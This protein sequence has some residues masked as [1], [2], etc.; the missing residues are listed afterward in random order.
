MALFSI[1]HD[2]IFLP[3]SRGNKYL[4]ADAL[5]DIYNTFFNQEIKMPRRGDVVK[6]IYV[7]LKKNADQWVDEGEKYLTFDDIS[8]RGKRV[9]RRLGIRKRKNE[10]DVTDAALQRANHMF[11]RLT[12]CGWLEQTGR[13]GHETVDMPIGAMRLIKS[14]VD[15]RKGFSPQ[16]G[17]LLAQARTTLEGVAG[18]P[19]ELGSSLN[20]SASD[21]VNFSMSMRMVLTVLRDIEKEILQSKTAKERAGLFFDK[22]VGM[23]L[24]DFEALHSTS[25]PYAHR[26][27]II[28]SVNKLEADGMA[29]R[30]IA[31][32][33]LETRVVSTETTE[34]EALE[35]VLEDIAQ[36][37]L[38]IDRIEEFFQEIQG[39]GRSLAARLANMA[40]YSSSTSNKNQAELVKLI[41]RIEQASDSGALKH[42]EV[43]FSIE[44]RPPNMAAWLMSEPRHNRTPI[45]KR[46]ISEKPKDPIVEFLDDLL[47]QFALR[48]NVTPQKMVSYLDMRVRPGEEID[49]RTLSVHSIDD[50][51]AVL[52]IND[53][54][55]G[56]TTDKPSSISDEFFI[57]RTPENENE[58]VENDWARY[59]NFSVRRKQVQAND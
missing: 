45:G 36:V 10:A 5:C 21:I 47:T 31:Q 49:A 33:Y 42:A 28:S 9:K 58:F 29:L 16:L 46:K 23:V 19:V 15:I 51:L 25:H 55:I 6:L 30:H 27:K 3:F 50:L 32:A 14:L 1:L 57:Y 18:N 53:R 34:D 35:A 39:F 40:R 17:G 13:A 12:N 37:R 56:R 41:N 2:D 4:Y 48:V 8:V 11:V 59:K 43:N 7:R 26:M 52:T 22:Y 44:A 20:K 24:R 38:G 54:S